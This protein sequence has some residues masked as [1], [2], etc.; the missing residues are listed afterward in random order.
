MLVQVQ[1]FP[2]LVLPVGLGSGQQV[3][4]VGI[5]Q[6]KRVVFQNGALGHDGD[7]PAGVDSGIGLV[8]GACRGHGT[9]CQLRRLG[10]REM[11]RRGEV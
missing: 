4:D 6:D 10:R 9:A 1:G 3:Q 11:K 8:L 5:L 2:A 7:D